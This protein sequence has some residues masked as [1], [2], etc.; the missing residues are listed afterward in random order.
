[1]KSCSL[2]KGEHKQS[3]SEKIKWQ[4]IKLQ[5]KEQGKILQE[6]LNKKVI[7]NSSEKE[8]RVMM[9][10]ITQDFRKRIEAQI[11]TIEERF[12]KDLE[13]LKN[14]QTRLNKTIIEIK[15]HQKESIIK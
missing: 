13:E 2:Q 11:E 15:I 3:K 1:M 9:L 14:K 5:V 6:W 8:F 4:A 12:Y 10:K 7:S